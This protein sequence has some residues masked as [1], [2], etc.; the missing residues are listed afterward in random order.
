MLKLSRKV[1][2]S[3]ELFVPPGAGCKISV[4]L[5]HPCHGKLFRGQVGVCIAAPREVQITRGE[6]LP[7]GG[8]E[9]GE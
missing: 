1:G 8:Q 6:L 9:V 4:I 2:Q 3:V 7:Q 5:D